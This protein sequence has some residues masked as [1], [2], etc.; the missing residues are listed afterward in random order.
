MKLLIGVPSL[1]F[2]HVE[3]LK[4]LHALTEHLHHE[5]VRFELFICNGTLAHVAREHVANHA[6]NG[7]FTHV[8]WLDADM[9][10]PETIL[11]DL[12]FCG[13]SFVTGIAASRR[14]PFTLCIFSDLDLNHLT[15][16][17]QLPSEAFRVAGCGFACVLIETAIM[18]DVLMNNHTMFLPMQYYGEDLAFCKR[19]SELGYEI[20]AEPSARLGHI[21]HN[22]VWPEDHEKYME[23]LSK[24]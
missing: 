16:V 11:E 14:P 20:W 24:G 1:D 10:F 15:R 21:G 6:I 5:G 4:S 8:L 17:E 19:A 13:K 22:A 2:V 18:K 3:F 12:Q 9:V 23:Q 7:D